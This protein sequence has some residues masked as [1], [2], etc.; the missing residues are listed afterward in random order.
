MK[1]NKENK[2]NIKKILLV[3]VLILILASVFLFVY[4]TI[5]NEK[6]EDNL[7]E[8]QDEKPPT[9][10]YFSAGSDEVVIT[11]FDKVL[12]TDK[13]TTVLSCY[14]LDNSNQLVHF[15][16]SDRAF[17]RILGVTRLYTGNVEI[18]HPKNSDGSEDDTLFLG[19]I[20]IPLSGKYLIKVCL[21]SS[22]NLDSE[23]TLIWPFGCHDSDSSEVID[24]YER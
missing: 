20:T 5:K 6:S 23:G 21:G 8:V 16:K 18:F 7:P 15:R 3:L 14:A 9:L 19:N 13:P 1:F 17:V 24:V 11:A 10:K 12:Y 22:I 2:K 4:L